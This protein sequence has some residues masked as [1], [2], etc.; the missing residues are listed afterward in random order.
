ML[1]LCPLI[2]LESGLRECLVT[3]AQNM[4]LSLIIRKHYY[5]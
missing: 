4:G 2:L 5:S 3:L 1:T